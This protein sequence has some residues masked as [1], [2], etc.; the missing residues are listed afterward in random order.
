MAH[1]GHIAVGHVHPRFLWSTTEDEH[2]GTVG[3]QAV[4]KGREETPLMVQVSKKTTT[5]TK[6][7][8]STVSGQHT[9][10]CRVLL[11]LQVHPH[12]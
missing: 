3:R 12:I 2:S 10:T 4:R 7:F 9:Q 5:T 1:K 8:A 6:T 11:H